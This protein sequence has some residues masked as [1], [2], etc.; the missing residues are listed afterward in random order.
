MTARGGGAAP[1]PRSSRIRAR[2]PRRPGR[3]GRLVALSQLGFPFAIGRYGSPVGRFRALARRSRY[4]MDRPGVRQIAGALAMTLAWPAGALWSAWQTWRRARADGRSYRWRELADMAWLAW[5]HSIPPREYALYRFE[6]APRRADMH[7]YV[8]WNDSA[9]LAALCARGG[10]DRRDVQDKH[11]FAAICAA[12]GLPHAPTLAVF[13]GGRQT[14]PDAP[15]TPD[16][17]A[18]WVKALRLNG[19][20]GAAKWVRDGGLYR[21]GN[22]R[23]VAIADF[24]DALRATDCLVQ[25]CL[26]NHPAVAAVSNGAL[27]ALRIVTGMRTDGQAEFVAALLWLPQGTRTTTAGAISCS[28]DPASGR[29]RRAATPQ[30]RPVEAHPDTGGPLVGLAVPFWRES[31]E[32]AL[33]AHAAAFARFPFLGWDVALTESGPVLLETNSGWGALFH[34]LL[35]GPLG[36]T[37]F[38]RL[39]A[40]HV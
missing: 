23:S 13:E 26:E 14:Y 38:S 35:D 21:S 39:V 27:A 1:A 25:P 24:A 31:C 11:R 40:Q 16:A 12:H 20:A 10:A 4:P 22:G 3:I 17:P 32:L 36:R 8:Y 6:A 15:F 18:L 5:R 30:G 29:V 9:G 7:E 33:R 37:A 34:Q 2:R 19:G 28:I